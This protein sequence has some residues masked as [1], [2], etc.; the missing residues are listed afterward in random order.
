MNLPQRIVVLGSEGA[1]EM[2]G[3]DQ[4]V[5]HTDDGVREVYR[6]DPGDGDPHLVPMQRWA[7]IVRDA[8]RTGVV[9]SGEPSFAD[10]AA[11]ARVMDALRAGSLSS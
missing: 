3:D 5:L 8:V 6:A 2:T 7:E 4:V 10:G 1:V 9:P 11:C